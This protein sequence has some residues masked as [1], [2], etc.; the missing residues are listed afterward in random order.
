MHQKVR[1][2]L[3]PPCE[4]IGRPGTVCSQRQV[5]A[6]FW[7]ANFVAPFMEVFAVDNFMQFHS[8][9]GALCVN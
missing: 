2:P 1:D 3:P 5:L 8:L 7:K 6:A 9:Q 4:L